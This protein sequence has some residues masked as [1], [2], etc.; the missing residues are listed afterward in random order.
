MKTT[1]H[2]FAVVAAFVLATGTFAAQQRPQ[3]QTKP[4]PENPSWGPETREEKRKLQEVREKHGLREA[5]KLYGGYIENVDFDDELAAMNVATLVGVSDLVIRGVVRSNRSALVRTTDGGYPEGIE[6]IKSDYKVLV[7][8]VY[9]GDLK[10]L[11]RE[12]TVRIPGGRMEFEGGLYAEIRTPGFVPP[13]DHQEFIWFLDLN[14]PEGNRYSLTFSQQGLFELMPEGW[15]NP[16]AGLE[17]PLGKNAKRDFTQ[18][19][20]QLRAALGLV[21]KQNP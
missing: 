15:V 6:T 2:L 20:A 12:I 10:L 3:Q 17:S 18:F 7:L 1:K 14:R 16:R 21:G 5:A 4:K 8:D 19:V 11:G 9:K 13:L